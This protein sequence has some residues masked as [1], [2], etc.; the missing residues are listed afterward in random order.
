MAG[1]RDVLNRKILLDESALDGVLYIAGGSAGTESPA[2][3]DSRI[4]VSS[5]GATMVYAL[6]VEVVKPTAETM[7]DESVG[8]NM[9]SLAGKNDKTCRTEGVKK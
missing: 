8:K 4:K 1:I 5:A 9:S 2:G 6:R 7:F 3:C